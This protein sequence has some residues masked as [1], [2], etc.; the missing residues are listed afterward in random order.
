[1]T[2][3]SSV[4]ARKRRRTSSGN[5]SDTSIS[6]VQAE[7]IDKSD[8]DSDPEVVEVATG[9]RKLTFEERFQTSTRTN[10]EVL[11]RRIFHCAH[12]D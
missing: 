5:K 1:M 3:S 6:S 9:G 10:K 12:R 4:Q 7:G 11:G 2:K 8:S